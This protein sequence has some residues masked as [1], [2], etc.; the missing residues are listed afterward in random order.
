MKKR[1]TINGETDKKHIAIMTWYKYMNYGSALQAYAINH[2][3]KKMGYLTDFVNYNPSLVSWENEPFNWTDVA[4]AG[5]TYFHDL[6]IK[7]EFS[8]FD[9]GREQLYTKFREEYFTETPPVQTPQ[10][11]HRLNRTFDAFV[12]GSDQIWSPLCFDPSYF[13]DFVDYDEKKIAYA[14][15][16]GTEVINDRDIKLY[17]AS[18]LDRFVHLSCRENTGKKLIE[19]LSGKACEHV[20]DP[21]LLLDADEW[22]LVA[23]KS[24]KVRD[25]RYCLAYFLGDNKANWN[26]AK[27]IAENKGLE[28]V[29]VPVSGLDYKKKEAIA[30]PVGPAELLT[31]LWNADYVCTD[32]YHGLLFS[33]NF[34][35]NFSIFN[36]FSYDD[37]RCQNSRIDSC[38]DMFDLGWRRVTRFSDFID[39]PIN[40]EVVNS[41]LKK[42]R[43]R[44]LEYLK[45]SLQSATTYYDAARE[46]LGFLTN[47]CVACGAC[48]T[49]CPVGAIKFEVDSDGFERALIDEKVCIACEKCSSVCPLHK[50]NQSKIEKDVPV[51]AFRCSSEDIVGSSSGGFA[52]AAGEFCAAKGLGVYGSIYDSHI[53]KARHILGDSLELRQRMR[54]SK[55]IKSETRDLFREI[56]NDHVANGVF[57]GTPCQVA[58]LKKC[59]GS[60]AANWLF[61][62]LV[63]HGVPTQ[64]LWDLYIN[65]IGIS[66]GASVKFRDNSLGWVHR[67]ISFFDENGKK[68]YSNDEFHDLFF[69]LFKSGVANYSS[70]EN[71]PFRNRSAADLR[72]GDYWSE[73]YIKRDFKS[74]MVLVLSKKGQITL[75]EMLKVGNFDVERKSSDDFFDYQC[76]S[77]EDR[78]Y[79]SM[80]RVKFLKD[81]GQG[82]VSLPSLVKE[83]CEPWEQGE[84]RE[85]HIA[86]FVAAIKKVLGK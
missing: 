68:I 67:N 8:N 64:K 39:E 10:D 52:W 75:E 70:C 76:I 27:S 12:C 20:L 78:R 63:C 34:N 69:R 14:P 42:Q 82:N 47:T 30:D 84:K 83:Y 28:L 17:M 80:R 11:L 77:I 22:N 19:S 37:A 51:Y 43:M 59:I 13:L 86:P 66:K 16:I 24:I 61:V 5:I 57:F 56:H 6:R 49:V 9:T 50:I 26:L 45:S 1:A 41:Q 4:S 35:K 38:L 33:I 60:R 15:S 65:S 44:S 40:Y 73:E 7:P 3:I 36:R 18:L 72:I 48:E 55:Y 21:T 23:N 54:G 25:S 29:L 74:S 31:L 81:L 32:S 62:D 58:A 46:K 71:C 53:C 85:K 2:V 79:Y